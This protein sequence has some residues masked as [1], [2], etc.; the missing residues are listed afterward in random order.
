[1]LRR[2]AEPVVAFDHT[3]ETLAQDLVDSLY[4]HKGAI[5]L[6]APQIG[7]SLRVMVIDMTANTTRD[8]PR[9]LVNP[10]IVAQS[11]QKSVREGCLSFPDYLANVRRCL[12]V[13]F[14]ARDPFGNVVEDHVEGLE[15]VCVQHELD[16]LD[17]VLMIDRVNSL[18][19]DWIRRTNS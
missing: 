13:H 11:R 2:P 4:A 14:V 9:V 10:V 8:R 16:H 17:G 7:V 6:A 15:A 12:R 18:N 3:L 5:G 1:M 19:S